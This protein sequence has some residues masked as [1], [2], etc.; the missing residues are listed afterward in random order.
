M[1]ALDA[2]RRHTHARLLV[3]GEMWPFANH[4]TDPMGFRVTLVC[5]AVVALTP[6]S[7][8]GRIWSDGLDL[9]YTS[10]ANTIAYRLYLPQN[11]NPNVEYPLAVFQHG[12]G[13]RGD[14]GNLSTKDFQ[15]KF[16][17]SGLIDKTYS[18]YPAILVVPQ[19]KAG[20]TSWWPG[21]SYDL[22]PG[23]LQNVIGNYSVDTDRLYITGL[24]LGGFGA[25]NYLDWYAG[26]GMQF[27]AAVPMSGGY[28]S[29]YNPALVAD[30]KDVPTWL[31]HG[32]GDTIVS[33]N[34]SRFTYR[35]LIGLAPPDPIVFDQTY[36]GQPTAVH[37]LTRYTE[38]PL[39][40]HG[41]WQGWYNDNQLYDW[42]F[43]QAVPEPS[44]ATLASIGFAILTILRRKRSCG[45]RQA[46]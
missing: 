33:P 39:I 2:T 1:L 14:V 21:N 6:L 36:L 27:A 4:G 28:I 32:G 30:F 9:T 35:S 26:T 19:L 8:L 16:H 44:S 10:G 7:A 23:I 25:M 37:G 42:M 22:T 13:E 45:A 12:A 24:S 15:V 40:N 11:Y 29:N 46:F 38:I 3:L 5:V 18:Q 41:G 17:I 34:Y 31:I 43:A 20:S